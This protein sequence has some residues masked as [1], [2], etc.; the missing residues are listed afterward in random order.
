MPLN[1]SG[2][3]LMFRSVPL[4]FVF[5]LLAFTFAAADAQSRD[6]LKV[7]AGNYELDKRHAS[8]VVRVLHMG[9]SHYTMRFN[10]LTG[11]F[12]FDPAAMQSPKVS[13][14]VDPTSIDTEENA[15]NKTVAGYFEPEKYPAILFNAN[16][17]AMTGEGQGQLSG[18]LTLHGVT[19][20]V[21]LD[22]AFN[23]VGPGLT[24]GTRVGFSGTGRIKRSEFGVTGGRPFA[25]DTVDLM[26]EVE[27][28]KK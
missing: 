18:D 28:Y 1:P 19:K 24:G 21:T 14:S 15:F 17:L 16:S 20:P 4:A 12:T 23:G 11:N 7:P 8:L 10:R 13:I 22:I 3:D 2:S 27:F 25:G 26:F 5:S 9:F 6:P